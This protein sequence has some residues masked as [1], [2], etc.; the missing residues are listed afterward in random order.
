M[1]S[2]YNIQWEYQGFLIST[3]IRQKI[4]KSGVSDNNFLS[5]YLKNLQIKYYEL[6]KEKVFKDD[7]LLDLLLLDIKYLV[8]LETKNNSEILNSIIILNFDNYITKSSKIKKVNDILKY[9]YINY[10]V[11]YFLYNKTI[12]KNLVFTNFFETKLRNSI[13][14]KNY[15][16]NKEARLILLT[17]YIRIVTNKLFHSKY[18]Y[19]YICNHSDYFHLKQTLQASTDFI[20]SNFIMYKCNNFYLS[21]IDYIINLRNK[22]N[23]FDTTKCTKLKYSYPMTKITLDN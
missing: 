5:H 6:I 15:H 23:N 12:N 10:I 8:Y 2:P 4:I 22:I 9:K 17:K 16:L 20:I 1:E 13:E 11:N 7:L 21:L 14:N 19:Y 3:A 18:D